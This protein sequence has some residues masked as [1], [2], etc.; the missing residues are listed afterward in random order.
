MP[1][2]GLTTPEEV[3]KYIM[4]ASGPAATWS[5][6]IEGLVDSWF[7]PTTDRTYYR[8]VWGNEIVEGQGKAFDHPKFLELLRENTVDRGKDLITLG[9]DGSRNRDTTAL[10]ATSVRTCHQWV[11]GV[12]KRPEDIKYDDEWSVDS[13]EVD[14]LVDEY[15]TKW[16][17][18]RLYGD[19]HHWGPSM[20]RWTGKYG[21]DKVVSW[22]TT[23]W[24]T[25]AY[26]C[27]NFDE[28]IRLGTIHFTDNEEGDFSDHVSN[29]VK[30]NLKLIDED[31]EE[32]LWVITKSSKN[33][34]KKIDIAMAAILS[35]EARND[36]V[37]AGQL[38]P[39][40]LGQGW[41]F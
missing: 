8:R 20:D 41:A 27:R 19:P 24:K 26:A 39:V 1:P 15:M 37:A 2:G 33:S 32:P 34:P 22:D 30:R 7:E 13:T 14:E 17:V 38:D 5:G 36:A 29:A 16:H 9:F 4:E 35:L 23:K 40:N 21:K 18:W 28:A 3:R 11:L 25:I 12:W 31:T 6:D 10:V